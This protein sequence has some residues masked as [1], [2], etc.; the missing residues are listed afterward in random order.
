MVK[1]KSLYRGVFNY[2]RS[3]E[4]P[5]YR[6]AFTERQAWKLMCDEIARRH[7][8]HP[9]YVYTLFDGS[10]GNFEITLEVDFREGEGND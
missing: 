8:I 1:V 2:A 9:S 6:Y 3:V 10:R 4:R 7:E 5:I